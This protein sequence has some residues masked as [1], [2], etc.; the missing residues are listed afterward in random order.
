VFVVVA[1]TSCKNQ[2]VSVFP[3][4]YG[5]TGDIPFLSQAFD[6]SSSSGDFTTLDGTT[7]L[8]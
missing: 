5:V 6:G 1:R 7:R 2:A 4:V 3:S 8:V